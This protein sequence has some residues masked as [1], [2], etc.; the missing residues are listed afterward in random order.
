[1]HRDL[2]R[3]FDHF[4]K[5]TIAI[6]GSAVH[7]LNHARDIDV[8]FL[9]QVNFPAL[10]RALGVT[11]QGWNRNGHHIRRANYTIPGMARSL[12]LTHVNTVHDF[13]DHPHCC[14]LRDGTML[15]RGISFQ[16]RHK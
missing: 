3:I 13:S 7:D 10:V 12:Q 6:I 16:K 4:S 5:H 1:M 14:L 8:L 15:N 2:Q 11:Y 9:S